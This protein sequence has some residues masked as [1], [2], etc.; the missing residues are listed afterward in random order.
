VPNFISFTASI[1]ELAHGEKSHTRSLTHLAYLMP[2]GPKRLSQDNSKS[3]CNSIKV[4][5][6]TMTPWPSWTLTTK[7]I[8]GDTDNNARIH[9]SFTTIIEVS[10]WSTIQAL[11]ANLSRLLQYYS[12]AEALL[13]VKRYNWMKTGKNT[14]QIVNYIYFIEF[15]LYMC[16]TNGNWWYHS[17]ELE[18]SAGGDEAPWLVICQ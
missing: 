6:R 3:T 18:M 10:Q 15:Q 2:P 17:S 13:D 9:R 8:V 4:C 14:Q 12:Q 1:A 7:Q 16:Q 5:S 11:Q